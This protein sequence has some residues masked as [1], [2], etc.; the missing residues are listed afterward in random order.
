MAALHINPPENF[1]FSKPSNWSKWKIRLER[2]RI[3]SGLSAKT[4]NEQKRYCEV[5][6]LGV[7][8]LESKNKT[9]INW[10]VTVQV[11]HKNIKFKI[12]SGAD[13]TVLP[14]NVFE[15]VLQNAK[16]E[17][18]DKIL[19]GPD[20]N[21]LKTLRKFRA[22]IEY[23][24]K[25]CIEE[26]YVIASLQMCLLGK[27]ALSSL[28]LFLNLSSICQASAVDPKVIFPDHFIGLGIME[29]F[30]SIK[31][32]P[33]AI[34]FAITSPRCVPFPFLKQTEA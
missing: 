26:I 27:P 22:I 24:G 13:H 18:R 21:Q 29:G 30:Y 3:A 14:A 11:N 33:G 23:K 34:P 4:G 1:T 31:L 12:D 19:C 17:P 5:S 32:K 15:N 7:V 9:N 20:K 2:Y 28:G 16:L 8:Q 6:Y 10:T 25:N